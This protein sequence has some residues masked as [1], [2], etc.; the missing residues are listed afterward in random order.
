MEGVLVP[1][2]GSSNVVEIVDQLDGMNEGV[3]PLSTP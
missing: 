2:D 1:I 3:D